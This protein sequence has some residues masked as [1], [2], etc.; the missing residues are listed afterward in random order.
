MRKVMWSFSMPSKPW[1]LGQNFSILLNGKPTLQKV[2]SLVAILMRVT[3][4]G[5]RSFVCILTAS[6]Y[7][8]TLMIHALQS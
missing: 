4:S 6:V 2:C 1:R 5:W 8:M 7:D 3:A